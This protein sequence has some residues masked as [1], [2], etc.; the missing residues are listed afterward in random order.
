[1]KRHVNTALAQCGGT[2]VIAAA[3]HLGTGVI[4]LIL[5]AGLLSVTVRTLGP[6]L[7]AVLAIT[8]LRTERRLLLAAPDEQA[9]EAREVLLDLLTADSYAS[10]LG[11]GPITGRSPSGR[12][13]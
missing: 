7:P 5:A 9:R 11:A 2:A 10:I 12:K 6:L 3:G 1:M 4:V 13:S 8:A